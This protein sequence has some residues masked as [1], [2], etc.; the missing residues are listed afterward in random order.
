MLL[1]FNDFRFLVENVDENVVLSFG[2]MNPPTIG[3]QKLMRK[4]VE[5]AKRNNAIPM[6]FL[7][8]TQDR[9]KNRNHHF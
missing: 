6:L 2:R 3:H 9:K 7:S 5:V 4:I 8:H 1:N